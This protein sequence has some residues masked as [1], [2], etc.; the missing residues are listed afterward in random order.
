METITEAMMT[1]WVQGYLSSK[2][3]TGTTVEM[4]L[5]VPDPKS[6]KKVLDRGCALVPEALIFAVADDLANTLTE[7]YQTQKRK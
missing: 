1:S 7:I 4:V 6:I 3:S 5:E 2:N